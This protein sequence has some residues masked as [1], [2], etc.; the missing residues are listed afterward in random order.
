MVEEQEQ[1]RTNLRRPLQKERR[2]PFHFTKMHG[3]GNDY[4][5][6]NLFEES[7]TPS[8]E[9]ARS[10]SDRHRGI[11]GD[12]VIFLDQ[13]GTGDAHVRMLMFNSDGSRAQMCGNGIRCLAKLAY[14]S[15]VARENPLRV[16][17]DRGRLELELTVHDGRVADVRV[18][19]GEPVLEPAQIP[20]AIGGH[21]AVAIPFGFDNTRFSMTCVSM[22]NPHAVF[23]VPDV[24]DVPVQ[25]WG[26]RI[27]RHDMFPERVNVHFAQVAW[28][29]RVRMVTWERGAGATLACGTGAAAVCV[30]GVLNNVSDRD[31]TIELP[32][33]KLE[34]QWRAD[35]NRVYLTGAAET[36]FTGTWPA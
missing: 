29:D 14:E 7:V 15:G 34:L 9:L 6:I 20:V 31:V 30:A 4:V 12:G 32:G 2:M 21:K 18:D 27:E 33:G 28:P 16:Q 3:L 8:E 25:D 24:D 11:G 17:T 19:M 22:G 10:L 26:R 36:V 35:T 13:P 23:F 1:C 5:F